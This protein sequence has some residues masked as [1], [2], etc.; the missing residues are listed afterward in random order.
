MNHDKGN[1]DAQEERD[2]NSF[3]SD[4]MKSLDGVEM[5]RPAPFFFTRVKSRLE[6][7]YETTLEP[8]WLRLFYHSQWSIFSLGLLLAINLGV[9]IYSYDVE[10]I[11]VGQTA[12]MEVLIDEYQL[13]YT[14]LYSYIEE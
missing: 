8:R 6:K 3:V 12:K 4:V 13:E 5:S 10:D 11:P 7:T 1:R 2:V 9:V 14:S